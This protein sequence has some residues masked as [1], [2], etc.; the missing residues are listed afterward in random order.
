MEEGQ[1]KKIKAIFA[2]E[3]LTAQ[4]KQSKIAEIMGY[5]TSAPSTPP[6]TQHDESDESEETQN[7]EDSELSH[8]T[9]CTHYTR[10]CLVE[11]DKCL[12]FVE[13]RLCHE[14]LDRFSIQSVK[15]KK[16]KLVQTPK[17]ICE[18]SECN[19]VFGEYFCSVCNLFDLNINS[20]PKYHCEL[21]GICRIGTRENTFHCEK[22][23]QCWNIGLRNTHKC[24]EST[25]KEC[26][27]CKDRMDNTLFCDP[28]EEEVLNM[29]CGH[30]FHRGC[31]ASYMQRDYRCPMCRKSLVDLTAHTRNID[32]QLS[33]LE[34]HEIDYPES[35]RNKQMQVL[36]NECEIQFTTSFSPFQIYKCCN[37]GCYNTQL[38][39]D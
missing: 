9:P 34:T 5:K 29:R 2:N 14:E 16:C 7:S 38:V 37:C 30:M 31:V 19:N 13:C 32:Q 24:F 4:E 11:C 33:A 6:Q 8:Q 20:P 39:K 1:R 36:C 26:C 10:G 18:N 23:N 15:C 21:C 35:L 17:K 25:V 28:T 27:I 12:K 22:C 3:S